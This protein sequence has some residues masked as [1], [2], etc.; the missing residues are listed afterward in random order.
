M[1]GGDGQHGHAA[2]R[3]AASRIARTASTPASWRRYS[4]LAWMSGSGVTAAHTASWTSERSPPG[5][6]ARHRLAQLDD[7]GRRAD[8]DERCLT[9]LKLAV[10]VNGDAHGDAADRVVAVAAGDLD[11][12]ASVAWRT[13]RKACLHDQFV[14]R[15]ARGKRPD[16][17]LLRW[18]RPIAASRGQP[19]RS[20]EHRQ[21]GG[22]LAGR[23]GVRQAP[24][25]RASIADRR[26]RD[27]PQGLPEQWLH[28]GG[29]IVALDVGLP[30][31]RADA[32][33]VLVH[34]DVGQLGHAVDVDSCRGAASRIDSNGTRLWPPASTLASLPD[35]PS[36]RTAV[37]ERFRSRVA[38]RRWLHGCGVP[39]DSWLGLTVGRNATTRAHA[40]R[41]PARREPHRAADAG[42]W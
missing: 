6:R 19:D 30:G 35:S 41:R 14:G 4:A 7:D 3:C 2:A 9:G 32:H 34:A 11:E 20:A 37:V 24:D 23:I 40:S 16:E 17:K 28:R 13:P 15:R 26:V 10:L 42:R 12:R 18:N 5:V 39:L 21:H 36:S 38:E 25:D 27:E 31:Q 8:R 29:P 33:G 22:E 1:E